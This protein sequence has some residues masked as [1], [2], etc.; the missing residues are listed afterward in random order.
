MP[1][2]IEMPV[3]MLPRPNWIIVDRPLQRSAEAGVRQSSFFDRSHAA[4]AGAFNLFRTNPEWGGFTIV[5]LALYSLVIFIVLSPPRA[6]VPQR[7]PSTRTE[8]LDPRSSTTASAPRKSNEGPVAAQAPPTNPRTFH[9]PTLLAEREQWVLRYAAANEKHK[10]AVQEWEA[11]RKNRKTPP[12]KLGTPGWAENLRPINISGSIAEQEIKKLDQEIFSARLF[13]RYLEEAAIT[14]RARVASQNAQNQNS[15]A[16]TAE[17][18]RIEAIRSGI[19][20][21]GQLM[22]EFTTFKNLSRT[23][24]GSK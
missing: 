9:L 1:A 18:L 4:L 19:K 7:V 24:S 22:L 15:T 14:S 12:S 20:G 5:Y 10:V 17:E 13:Q 21:A 11:K 8:T 23:I 2:T 3:V 6:Q 16:R